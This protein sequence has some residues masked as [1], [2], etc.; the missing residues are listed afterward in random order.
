MPRDIVDTTLAHLKK[1]QIE[2]MVLSPK[3]WTACKL[4]IPLSWTTVKYDKK[5]KNELPEKRGV[6]TFIVKP[7]I[8]GHPEC[9]YLLYVGQ[10]EA[11]TL[12][13]RFMQYFSE[14][15]KPKGREHIK[16]MARLWRKNLWYCY[17]PIDNVS[18]IEDI[19]KSLIKAFVPPLNRNFPG[20]LGK[21]K[22][23][24]S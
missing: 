11:Q 13:K 14:E 16:L 15:R 1:Y 21:A 6:Y 24:W 5:R 9:A 20:V 3:Y 10:T 12:R 23:A 17:A 4:P 22:R 18:L 2:R 7:N 19:E 8:V